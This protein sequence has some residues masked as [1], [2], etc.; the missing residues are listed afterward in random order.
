MPELVT[1]MLPE[2]LA[3]PLPLGTVLAVAAVALGG[4]ES[5]AL[6]LGEAEAAPLRLATDADGEAV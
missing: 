4:R 6:P 5:N 2:A 3:M 1:E